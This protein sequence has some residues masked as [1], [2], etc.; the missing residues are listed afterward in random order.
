M[1]I[2]ATKVVSVFAD[3]IYNGWE[4]EVFP[5]GVVRKWEVTEENQ[6]G[7]MTFMSESDDGYD[8]IKAAGLN[9]LN[10]NLYSYKVEDKE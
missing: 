8:E 10:G 9:V 1:K 5:N 2:S 3:V 6:G 7:H 4:Y